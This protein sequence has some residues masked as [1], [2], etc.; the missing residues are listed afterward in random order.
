MVGSEAWNRSVQMK[1]SSSSG[2]SAGNM[3]TCS[4]RRVFNAMAAELLAAGKPSLSSG[5][6]L[7]TGHM[8]A[9][10]TSEL[11]VDDQRV[12][13]SNTGLSGR[14]CS[15]VC[16]SFHA[17]QYARMTLDECANWTMMALTSATMMRSSEQPGKSSGSDD[18]V[19]TYLSHTTM[20]APLSRGRRLA[21]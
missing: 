14:E 15:V 6:S 17:L 9:K 20:F 3:L 13:T 5:M 18:P 4:V 8:H 19:A 2:S 16:S 21:V 7:S 12:T 1:K 10:R 11:N